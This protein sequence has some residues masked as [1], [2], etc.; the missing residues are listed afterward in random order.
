MKSIF[1][2]RRD[3]RIFDNI[4]L[5]NCLK[6]NDI[7]YPIFIF[8]PIQITDKNKYK[9]NNSI[10]FMIDSIKDLLNNINISFYY[11]DDIDVLNKLINDYDINNIYTNK[12]Y[13]PF[14]KQRDYILE[15]FCNKNQIQLCLYDDILLLPP[16]SI[17]SSSEKIY[18]KF[19]PYYNKFKEVSNISKPI[20]ISTDIIKQKCKIF[21]KNEYTITSNNISKFYNYNKNIKL[22]GGRIEGLKNLKDMYRNENKLFTNSSS[23]LSPYIKYGCVSIREVYYYFIKAKNEE[24]IRQLVWREFYY[25]IGFCYEVLNTALRKKYNKIEWNTNN[26]LLNKWKNAKTGFPVVDAIM[27][28]LNNTGYISNRSRLIVASYLVKILGHN[29]LEGEKYFAQKLID[30]DPLVNN[31]NWQWVA[32][33]G[34]DIQ[35][36]FR[37][38]NPWLQSEKYDNN[39]DYIKLWI[40]ELKN[41]EPKKIHN[42]Y[43]YF[44]ETIYI[45][46]IVDYKECKEKILKMYKRID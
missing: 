24:T 45:K 42:W 32:G 33:T 6:N 5:I 38:F 29:W 44:D 20:N 18:V 15:Q 27:R 14:A 10:Q 37:I 23:Q 36:Y 19:T 25:N 13:T 7:V 9:S 26:N 39:C 43:K 17:L 8:N 1:I 3:F 11:G 22:K 41:I 2:F 31:G 28:E 30:Y 21:D 40:P 12:D 46:P 35:P 34:A 4:G 16:T